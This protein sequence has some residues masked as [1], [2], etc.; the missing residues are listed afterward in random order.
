MTAIAGQVPAR[1][2]VVR[3]QWRTV[4]MLVVLALAIHVL[5][6]QVGE[7]EHSLNAIELAD[8]RW[9]PLGLA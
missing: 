6:P 5:L 8:W 7:L 2:P 4:L 9:L 3:V 1:V